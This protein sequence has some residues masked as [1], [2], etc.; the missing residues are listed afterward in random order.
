V[1]ENDTRPNVR[2]CPHCVWKYTAILRNSN[3]KRRTI[4]SHNL[5]SYDI[6]SNTNTNPK[7]NLHNTGP[8]F[9]KIV[10][11]ETRELRPHSIC[12]KQVPIGWFDVNANFVMRGIVL[13]KM[14]KVDWDLNGCTVYTLRAILWEQTP[15]WKRIP[16]AGKGSNFQVEHL[17]FVGDNEYDHRFGSCMCCFRDSRG[18]NIRV[19]CDPDITRHPCRVALADPRPAWLGRCGCTICNGCVSEMEKLFKEK[20]ISSFPCPYCGNDNSFFL[21]LKIWPISHRVFL[22]EAETSK[23]E[24]I[25]G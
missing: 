19:F 8:D 15:D 1:R 24:S 18:P 3:H 6:M 16:N 2:N 9:W 21:E 20:K 12:P 13:A 25:L 22:R 5:P 4:N 7:S 17:H 10:L 11:T 23:A 14:T